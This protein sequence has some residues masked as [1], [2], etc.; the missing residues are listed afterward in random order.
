M[1]NMPAFLLITRLCRD[2][3]IGGALGALGIALF[4]PNYRWRRALGVGFAIVLL[5]IAT[6]LEFLFINGT[7]RP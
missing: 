6:L 5:I 2:F 4:S 7:L 3:F 1:T